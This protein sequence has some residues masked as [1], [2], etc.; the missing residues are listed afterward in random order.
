MKEKEKPRKP[1]SVQLLIRTVV[2]D[3]DGKIIND[4]GQHPAK[5]FV[6]QFLEFIRYF[7]DA[8]GISQKATAT[9]GSEDNIYYSTSLCDVHFY[10]DAP[11]AL[12]YGPN[13]GIVIGTGNTPAT[14]TDYKLETKLSPPNITCGDSTVGVA[15]VVGANVD[16]TIT[17]A[18]TNNTG[19]TITVREAGMYSRFKGGG[20]PASGLYHCII[21]DVLAPEVTLPDKCTLTVYYTIRTTV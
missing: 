13:W 2:K 5:S 18:F 11:G 20:A 1:S 19:S 12:E 4:S 21:R 10:V 14:N 6:L 9:D 8:T 15:A 3:P 7:F 17:R 16:L